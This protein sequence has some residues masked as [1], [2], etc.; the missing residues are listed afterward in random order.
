M[1][2]NK[3]IFFSSR[4]D[5]DVPVCSFLFTLFH[6]SFSLKAH[7]PAIIHEMPHLPV[8]PRLPWLCQSLLGPLFITGP[9][10]APSSPH[11]PL[12]L[13]P[14]QSKDLAKWLSVCPLSESFSIQ[15]KWNGKWPPPRPTML[16]RR[17]R[18]APT[19]HHQ[20]HLLKQGS[21]KWLILGIDCSPPVITHRSVYLSFTC[22]TT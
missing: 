13:A 16:P 22:L 18:W 20:P 11:G 9:P 5:N 1:Y 3:N 2:A 7:T 14:A 15:L 12:H 4:S 10:Q 19:H 6:P 8:S 17:Y 21:K